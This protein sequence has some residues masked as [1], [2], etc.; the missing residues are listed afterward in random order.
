MAD[1][2][3]NPNAEPEEETIDL[4]DLASRLWDQRKKLIIWSVCGAVLGL[5]IAFSIP[6]EYTTTVKLA[7]EVNETKASSNFSALASLAGVNTSS[8]SG[9]DAVY[10][11]LYPDVVGSVPFLT[12]LF[13]TKVQTEEG[14]APIEL[15]TYMEEDM[16]SPWWSAIIG[17]PF[18]LLALLKEDEP[19][20]PTHTLDNFHLTKSE[21]DIVKALSDCISATVD[22]KTSVVTLDVTLQDPL[23]SAILA[24]TVVNRLKEYITD[25]RTNKSRQDLL[26]AEHLNAEAQAKYYKA[27]QIYANY[28]DRNQGLAF[29]SA[30]IERERLENEMALAYNLYNS[31][32]MQVQKAQAKVQETTPVYAV[33]TPATVPLK[34]S[35]PRKAIILIGFTFLAFMS[36]AVWILFLQPMVKSFKEKRELEKSSES[37]AVSKPD[38]KTE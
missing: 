17:A 8:A 16:K 25:Y 31:T 11:M 22:T 6:R 38:N 32:S 23:A 34:P 9:A 35:K 3:Q 10:P 1:N 12:S 33:I 37:A 2:H 26:Y 13:D 36:C 29:R 28:L 7:P 5:I 21:D 19:E 27:Q 18:K 14:D 20:D 24:D 30:Q 4:L 15:T